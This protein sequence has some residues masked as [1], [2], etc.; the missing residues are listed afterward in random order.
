MRAVAYDLR[1]ELNDPRA[2][3]AALG[4]G[5]HPADRIRQSR[6][7]TVRCPRHG[8]V[9]CSV[10]RGLD[11][12]VRVKCFGCDFAG[13][14]L[15]L[16]AEVHGLDTR[17][18]C[19]EVLRVAA[20][21]ARRSDILDELTPRLHRDVPRPLAA[22]APT[23]ATPFPPA[24][25]LRSLWNKCG[26]CSDDPEVCA[27]LERR[28]IRPAW[29]DD[30][31]LARVI[32]PGAPLPTWA[33]F[34]GKRERRAPWTE[35]GHRLLLPVYDEKGCMRNVRAWCVTP[36]EDPKRLPPAGY[37]AS[38]LVLA[39]GS[40]V[41]LLTSGRAPERPSGLRVLIVEGEPDFLTWATHFSDADDANVPVVFGVVSGS[42]TEDIAARIP[43]GT[44]VIVRTHHDAAGDGYAEVIRRTLQRRCTVVRP[45]ES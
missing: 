37:R 7:L 22:H 17:R 31:R 14:A 38:G 13:D 1:R 34:R 2:L 28:C 12:T 25:E 8:G 40:A 19:T 26:A 27:M 44:R 36:S 16:I 24:D 29:V 5:V 32:T 33:S 39:C 42:W 15:H 9:S 20:D 43:D 45:G 23:P 21:L 10:T 6:G 18:H 30:F 41:V 4:L 3:C 11:G 35:T